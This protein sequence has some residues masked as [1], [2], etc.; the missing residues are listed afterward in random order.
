MFEIKMTD[1]FTV[2]NELRS[3][4]DILRRLLLDDATIATRVI[5][6]FERGETREIEKEFFYYTVGMTPCG[7][8]FSKE[9]LVTY[10]RSQWS[11][12]ND[13]VEMPKAAI[14]TFILKGDELVGIEVA[15]SIEK[16]ASE[17]DVVEAFAEVIG[18]IEIWSFEINEEVLIASISDHV[19]EFKEK[20]DSF[21]GDTSAMRAELNKRLDKQPDL[22]RPGFPRA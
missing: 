4:E 11:Q 10:V 1:I 5:K 13:E 17:A 18:I 15:K 20:A 8:S 3:L 12:D 14:A 9:E 21:Q 22:S 19:N 6:E 7:C 16:P 2:S